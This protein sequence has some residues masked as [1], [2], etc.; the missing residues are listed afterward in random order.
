MKSK[1]LAVAI[2]VA[3]LSAAPFSVFAASNFKDVAADHPYA[4]AIQ[5]LKEKGIVRGYDGVNFG[6]ENQITRAELLKIALEGA[7]I[8]TAEWADAASPFP[9]VTAQNTLRQYVIYA[10][11]KGIVNGY[12]D[13]T[14]R[15]SQSTSRAEAI[16]M[17]LNI[18]KVGTG[19]VLSS[20]YTDLAKND[21]LAPYVIAARAQ[22]IIPG[23]FSS[24]TL[25][26]GEAIKRGEVAEMM[27]R[28][29]YLREHSD[30][31]IYPEPAANVKVVEGTHS[32]SIFKNM[33][34]QTPIAKT[35]VA[36]SYYPVTVNTSNDK[37]K[38]IIEAENGEQSVW[39]YKV[40]N[41]TA[42]FDLYFPE[43]GQY[44]LALVADDSK[45]SPS[46]A[47][48][49]VNEWQKGTNDKLAALA[50]AQFSYDAD[51]HTWLM[52]SGSQN[53][54]VFQ[55]SCV[56]GR[57]EIARTII[58][59]GNK[60]KVDYQMFTGFE[61]GEMDCSL[62][63][64]LA[65]SHLATLQDYSAPYRWSFNA[66]THHFRTW[67]KANLLINDALPL[68][69][70][71]TSL[72]LNGKANIPLSNYAEIILPSGNVQ[73]FSLQAVD[74]DILNSGIPWELNIQLPDSG[75]YF[76][77]VNDT[78]GLAV[79]NTPIYRVEGVPILPDFIA[80]QEGRVVTS[81]EPL[82]STE[83]TMMAQ[84]LVKKINDLRTKLNRTPVAL[85][86]DLS[87]FAQAHADDMVAKKYFSHK[88]KNGKGPDQR[89]LAFDIVLPVGEN[90]AFSID[91]N[92][93]DE[94]L[95]R[96]A[97][98]RLNLLDQ[99]WAQV[100]IGLARSPEGFLYAVQE[101]SPRS[102]ISQPITNSEKEAIA[103]KT[104]GR[105]NA[106]RANVNLPALT[107]GNEYEN[108]IAQWAENPR[109]ESLRTLLLDAGMNQGRILSS[110]GSYSVNLP[111]EL[112]LQAAV[113]D[114]TISKMAMG[115]AFEGETMLVAVVLY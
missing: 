32:A 96:S 10:Q 68:F 7:G 14:Y 88:D 111:A 101:F 109:S 67:D 65:A 23:K 13:G 5:V 94:G 48:A 33:T 36:N 57:K 107:L 35:M 15:P 31:E 3:Q 86:A 37:V 105:I 73:V 79:L 27:Y 47:I 110:E 55:L 66:L 97:V 1:L 76:L 102:F 89:K 80:A 61:E 93:I 21:P 92:S 28:L 100:G 8:D 6:P 52:W 2:I 82:S 30:I 26:T 78:E 50:G 77:E 18:N 114:S 38:V 98:H 24:K 90:I 51:G 62:T 83:R 44:H 46:V 60:W 81:K 43:A 22:K 104:L 75:V 39:E 16:K 20:P 72:K 53:R 45:S 95:K 103:E 63:Q 84:E 40:T 69:T 91:L 115:I 58:S 106:N 71:A 41:G 19:A 42:T 64:A 4:N 17:L 70:T 85:N 74:N 54:T 25:G 49:V 12:S 87:R 11:E 56:Q 108:A 9:D 113:T 99:R 112:A 29:L 59:S 34:I